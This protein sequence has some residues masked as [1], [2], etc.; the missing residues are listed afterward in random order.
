MTP[1]DT[2]LGT[3]NRTR[4][5]HHL[6]APLIPFFFKLNFLNNVGYIGSPERTIINDELQTWNVVFQA[7]MSRGR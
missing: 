6:T 2:H 1:A 5:T 3:A 7:P 4:H